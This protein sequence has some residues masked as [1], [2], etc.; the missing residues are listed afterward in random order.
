M[1]TR[2]LTLLQQFVQQ[3]QLPSHIG[4]ELFEYLYLG[5]HFNIFP[6]SVAIGDQT[7]DRIARQ[8]GNAPRPLLLANTDELVKFVFGNSEIYRTL[9][10]L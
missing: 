8:I 4:D 6:L 7:L 2:Q 5:R 10:R 9:S 3:L 1:V